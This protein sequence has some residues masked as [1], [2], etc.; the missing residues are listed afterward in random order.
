[1]GIGREATPRSF[2]NACDVF[3]YT[4]NLQKDIDGNSELPIRINEAQISH[5][6]PDDTVSQSSRN[7]TGYE[8]LFRRAV[9]ITLGDD[10]W[11][12]LGTLGSSLR[13]LDPAFDPRTYK[14]KS[15]SKLVRGNIDFF[16]LKEVPTSNGNIDLYVRLR[17]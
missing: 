15:L 14:Y 6:D 3:V 2:V 4:E 13:Q 5:T 12:H 1:M 17:E 8:E 7:R 16:D 11:I 9:D 10:G